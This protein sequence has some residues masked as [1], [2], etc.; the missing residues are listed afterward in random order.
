MRFA[1]ALT[2]A[3]LALAAIDFVEFCN[4]DDSRW[5]LSKDVTDPLSCVNSF[6]SDYDGSCDSLQDG[7]PEQ[8]TCVF[9][10]WNNVLD[11]NDEYASEEFIN[12]EFLG[13]INDDPMM[14]EILSTLNAQERF[15]S[16]Y[17]CENDGEG[18]FTNC[19][20]KDLC[21]DGQDP[22]IDN[23]ATERRIPGSPLEAQTEQKQKIGPD[24]EPVVD[25][26]GNPVME[27]PSTELNVLA[28]QSNL[29]KRFVELKQLVSWMQPKDK[30]IS[31]YCFYGCWCLPDGAH[32]FVAGE[33]HPVDLVDRACQL[34]WF[35]YVCAKQEMTAVIDGKEKTCIPDKTKYTFRF[36]YNKKKPNDYKQRDIVCKDNW[37]LP[38]NTREKWKSNCAKAFCECD[39][40]IAMR[41][42]QSWKHWDKSRH[43]IWSQRVT[44]CP[45][46]K[47]CEAMPITTAKNR[48]DREKCLRKG[49]LF[50]VKDRCLYGAGGRNE[51]DQKPICCGQYEDDG[52]RFEM[53]DHGGKFACCNH[54]KGTGYGDKLP[55]NG[56][57]YNK[58]T[59]CC[60]NGKV[61]A[62][63]HV[64][65]P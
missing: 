25:E 59:H 51:L 16:N 31:R 30:R 53:R 10:W 57:W 42:Y 33:G 50:I 63:G 38:M 9:D 48:A 49:C 41:L 2:S 23:C 3:P 55:W 13:N 64:D 20:P 44:E 56:A 22:T 7:S 18:G 46:K 35:C 58:L 4:N 19:K 8:H 29:L 15:L 26:E 1:A 60:A 24:G 47:A 52:S 54:H 12:N 34:F 5:N 14:A 17:E 27:T 28:G 65:C 40:G 11:S 39:R 61:E 62:A 32:S 45:T 43:R 36:K 21:G 37:Y 6:K